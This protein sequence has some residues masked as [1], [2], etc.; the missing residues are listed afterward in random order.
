MRQATDMSHRDLPFL[1]QGRHPCRQWRSPTELVSLARL[2]ADPSRL[3]RYGRKLL[4]KR[5]VALGVHRAHRTLSLQEHGE[6]L[7]GQSD[8]LLDTRLADRERRNT[9]Q[10][11]SWTKRAFVSSYARIDGKCS[12]H[13]IYG[14]PY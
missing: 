14:K 6:H 7:I 1:G 9:L 10:H 11:S 12:K 13:T 2:A 3:S 4:D 8:A 5:L